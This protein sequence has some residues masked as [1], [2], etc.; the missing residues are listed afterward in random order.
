[1][2]YRKE[3]LLDNKTLAKLEDIDFLTASEYK[4]KYG[5]EPARS[6][7]TID[8][9][10]DNGN[11]QVMLEI[12]PGDAKCKG[13]TVAKLRT[14]K[15]MVQ[16]AWPFGKEGKL[17]G[18]Y[19]F[20]F[21]DDIFI[22]DV[23]TKEKQPKYKPIRFIDNQMLR[24]NQGCVVVTL[25]KEDGSERDVFWA[26]SGK[27]MREIYN[28]AQERIQLE[29]EFV[30]T[31]M[32]KFK[33]VSVDEKLACIQEYIDK[34][35]SKGHEVVT[36]AKINL[37]DLSPALQSFYVES[38]LAKDI[39]TMKTDELEL[40]SN[41]ESFEKRFSNLVNKPFKEGIETVKEEGLRRGLSIDLIEENEIAIPYVPI[42]VQEMIE[43]PASLAK[44]SKKLIKMAKTLD[45]KNVLKK[46][47]LV[48]K[49]SFLKQKTVKK[50]KEFE[51]FRDSF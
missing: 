20:V 22:L 40:V 13:T 37:K 26:L 28:I 36:I 8:F 43:R 5:Q 23:K 42:W 30:H 19:R 44:V 9:G 46:T 33:F 24:E 50:N 10:M 1:M 31:G 7:F 14:E 25:Q 47:K 12:T 27:E 45:K 32:S 3:L 17:T 11:K 4:A 51:E 35:Q 18:E 6:V 29:E 34:E 39:A 2:E 21:D 41:I 48:N 15:G 49:S 16:S 38:A